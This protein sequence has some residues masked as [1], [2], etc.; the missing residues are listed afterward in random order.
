MCFKSP[1]S[2][3]QFSLSCDVKTLFPV[4]FLCPTSSDKEQGVSGGRKG[5]GSA[6][7]TRDGHRQDFSQSLSSGW[8]VDEKDNFWMGNNMYPKGHVLMLTST[9]CKVI[10]EAICQWAFQFSK[11]R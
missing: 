11:S 4:R 1:N 7:R 8:G 6:G 2:L 5:R 9:M 10:D 3:N